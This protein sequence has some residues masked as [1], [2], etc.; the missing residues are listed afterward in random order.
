MTKQLDEQS[1]ADMDLAGKTVQEL[2]LLVADDDYGLKSASLEILLGMG[3]ERIY[4]VL[5]MG[6]RNDAHAD[7]RN[8]SMELLVRFGSEALPYLILLLKD[9]NEE[10]R[11]FAAVMLGDIGNR[12]SVGALIK[13]LGDK[14]PNVSHSAAE[15]L[16]KIGDRSALFPLIE[17]LKGDFWVQY[18]AI[19]AISA[20]RDYRAVPH[21]LQL[22]DNELLAAPVIDALGEIA[23][24][25][26]LYPL[27]KILPQAEIMMAGQIAKAIMKIYR[28]V[29]ESLTFKNSLAEY[30][31]PEHLRN[32][33]D[34]EGIQKLHLLLE[35]KKE[36][37]IITAAVMLLGWLKD[38][39]ALPLFFRILENGAFIETVEAAIF[40]IGKGVTQTLS[41]AVAEENDNS[42]IVALRSLRHFG[43]LDHNTYLAPLL[44]STNESL[45]LEALEASMI[46]PDSSLLPIILQLFKTSSA[47]IRYKAA[48]LLGRYPFS[49][50][51]EFLKSLVY[52]EERESRKLGAYLLCHVKEDGYCR[53]LDSL[54]HDVDPEVRKTALQA[55]GIQQIE[56]AVTLISKALADPDISVRESAVVA[57]AEF[58]T[59]MLVD[60][61]LQLLGRNG[62]SLDYAVVKALGKMK[63]VTAGDSLLKYLEADD[64]SRRVEYVLIETLGKISAK[65]ASE[66][67]C[68]RYLTHSDAD[69][70]R[71]AVETLGRLGDGNSIQAV[72]AALNDPHWSVRVA[73]LHVLGDLGG[74]KELPLLLQAIS[75]PDVMVKKHAIMILGDLRN[76]AAIPA[77][78]QQLTDNEMSK[79]AFTALLKFGRSVLPW[80]HRQMIKN[81]PVE[82]RIRLIDLIG[83]IGDSKS[84]APLIE[85]LDDP[86]SGIRL[87]AI[88]S[89]A[90]CFDS[91][92]LKKLAS[93][94]SYDTDQEV[95]ERADLA[96]RTFTMEKYN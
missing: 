17:L 68:S 86:S 33:I 12:Q 57:V 89:A 11:N 23:D 79:Y 36:P 88:D 6:V 40:S 61:I 32:V 82:I 78:I 51:D 43:A 8:S 59:P 81:Y 7:I 55:V 63:A 84:V 52:C 54:I 16:G 85:L 42:R 45:Q 74:V 65:P 5:E 66:L 94:K 60:E 19:A 70:R 62:D 87:A 71:L 76:I 90:F 73:A 95:K 50:L 77:L 25:R 93:L 58:G 1:P 2:L 80:L 92:L 3:I 34:Q 47:E 91:M 46:A 10:V 67:I 35:S 69:L 37:E 24:P 21:L 13:S 30:Q 22:L 53:L 49:L 44:A 83:K 26:A 39:T 56:L 48:E 38:I 31:Q 15:A 14:D 96:L 27:G 20:M 9:S 64:L 4:P 41:V 72:E 29:T 75:D 18:S 28:N